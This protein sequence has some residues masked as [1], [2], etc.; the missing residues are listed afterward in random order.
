MC[1]CVCVW[2]CAGLVDVCCVLCVCLAHGPHNR[3]NTQKRRTL[4]QLARQRLVVL[5]GSARHEV[6]AP[7]KGALLEL[8]HGRED[9][10]GL[11][12]DVLHA[13]WGDW[14]VWWLVGWLVGWLVDLCT[15]MYADVLFVRGGCCVRWG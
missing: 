10:L 6:K 13:C 3:P 1:G 9:V 5:V 7:D 15:R 11:E 8:G 14:V 12:R 2:I 4:A